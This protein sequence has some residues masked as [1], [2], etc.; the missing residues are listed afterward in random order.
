[1]RVASRSTVHEGAYLIGNIHAAY[2]VAPDGRLLVLKRVGEVS[3]LIL[4]VDEDLWEEAGVPIDQRL[5]V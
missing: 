3:Q 4:E 2:D 1:M 5:A